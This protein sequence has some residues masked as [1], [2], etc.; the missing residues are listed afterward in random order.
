M[1]FANIAPAVVLA[2]IWASP[3]LAGSDCHDNLKDMLEGTLEVARDVGSDPQDQGEPADYT[4]TAWQ[5]P[6][7]TQQLY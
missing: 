3:V 7:T 1:R 5:A 4:L 2:L 6:K